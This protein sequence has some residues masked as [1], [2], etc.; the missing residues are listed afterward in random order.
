[1]KMLGMGVYFFKI[2]KIYKS[3][4]NNSAIKCFFFFFFALPNLQ[5]NPKGLDPSYKT[6]LSRSLRFR[7]LDIKRELLTVIEG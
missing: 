7:T 2:S 3:V 1:M 6:F 4:L 5:T